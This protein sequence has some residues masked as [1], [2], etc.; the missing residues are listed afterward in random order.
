M[1]LEK[2]TVNEMWKY[3]RP[4]I[5]KTSLKKIEG[6]ACSTIHPNLLNK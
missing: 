3:N 5:V 6:E 1:E 4:G 2:M